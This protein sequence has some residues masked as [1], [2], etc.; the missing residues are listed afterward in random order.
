MTAQGPMQL[1]QIQ[2]PSGPQLIAIP[3]NQSLSFPTNSVL[4]QSPT[5]NALQLQQNSGNLQLR[6]SP[7]AIIQPSSFP[8]NQ[9]SL[10][11]PIFQAGSA[12]TAAAGLKRDDLTNPLE[13]AVCL[14][15]SNEQKK[16]VIDNKITTKKN[17]NTVSCSSNSNNFNNG[18]N[19]NNCNTATIYSNSLIG[20]LGNNSNNN[21]NKKNTKSGK[22]VDEESLNRSGNR[23]FI[24]KTESVVSPPISLSTS[25]AP[26][27]ITSSLRQIRPGALANRKQQNQNTELKEKPEDSNSKSMSN[28]TRIIDSVASNTEHLMSPPPKIDNLTATIN[29][30]AENIKSPTPDDIMSNLT[31]NDVFMAGNKA[32]T[33]NKRPNL[34]IVQK[35]NK[36]TT[37]EIEESSMN[38]NRLIMSPSSNS[39]VDFENISENYD[40]LELSG[41]TTS[42]GAQTSE[43]PGF[44]ID[45]NTSSSQG[46]F[47]GDDTKKGKKKGCSKKK[48][49][50]EENK[51][52]LWDLMKSAGW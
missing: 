34:T 26:K 45:Q 43:S 52:D 51:V 35:L 39:A 23:N 15:G 10:Q 20:S 37:P 7:S 32:L 13:N 33:L 4:V 44:I 2:T 25:T 9:I 19:S 41:I 17:V 40:A 36:V 18:G 22:K 5:T 11:N 49:K 42:S 46:V 21:L 27:N 31:L 16:I 48:G 8:S 38:I 14:T 28:L 29:S 6:Q 30:V 12:S 47:Q 1:Q 24:G 3:Q 50:K